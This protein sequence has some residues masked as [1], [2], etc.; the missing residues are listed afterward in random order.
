MVHMQFSI[1]CVKKSLQVKC[2]KDNMQIHVIH[3]LFAGA[4]EET[5]FSTQSPLSQLQP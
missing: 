2:S 4:T 1:T 5:A 3:N